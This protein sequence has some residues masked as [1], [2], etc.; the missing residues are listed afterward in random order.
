MTCADAAARICE[1]I[2]Q[3]LREKER[4]LIAID[5]RCGAGKT[6]LAAAL[7]HTLSCTVLHMDDFFLR[8]HQRT[9]ARLAI[10]G[11]NVDHER[12]LDEVLT[13]LQ[14]GA[15]FTFRP[16]DCRRQD[17]GDPVSVIPGAVTVVEGSY[18]CHPDLQDA[19]DLRIFV[20]T[21]R[22]TQLSRIR[23]RGG[24]DAVRAF[25]EKWIPLEEAYFAAY[26]IPGRCHRILH[27]ED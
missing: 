23:K 5:G 26:D 21:D 24:E 8:P 19:Y 3:L 1:S 11:E 17:F 6:T 20:D 16:Y 18:S 15:P 10:P 4:I 2:G 9:E 12:F 22:E 25:R 7:A 13:P 27:L 14:S